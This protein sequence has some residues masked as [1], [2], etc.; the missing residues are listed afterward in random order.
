MVFD[1]RSNVK[2]PEVIEWARINHAVWVH[3]DDSAKR[4]HRKLIVAAD[5]RTVWLFRH[6]G[7][8]NDKEMLRALTVALPVILDQF[9]KHPNRR[10]LKV[11]CHGSE[12]HPA[13]KV[14]PYEIP[15]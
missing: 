11:T 4:E 7:K 12:P 5:I 3:A 2:D 10:H 1:K 9:T 15:K 13:I 14:E 6:K 8:M